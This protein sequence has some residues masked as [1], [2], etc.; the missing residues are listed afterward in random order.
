[1]NCPK[2]NFNINQGENFCRFCGYNLN[3]QKSQINYN[4]ISNSNT[5]SVGMNNQLIQNNIQNGD[6]NS[7]LQQNMEYINQN[8]SFQQLLSSQQT[9]EH[10]NNIY[11]KE[12]FKPQT[13]FNSNY[14]QNILNDE[15]FNDDILIDTY[16]GKRIDGLK[17]GGFSW[18]TFFGGILY[19]F[20]RKMWLLGIIWYVLLVIINNLLR[21]F[22]GIVGFII[23]IVI[24]FIFKERYLEHVNK[25]VEEIKNRNQNKTQDEIME[26]C[27]KKGGTTLIP[28]FVVFGIL[29][30]L[31]GIVFYDVI[32]AYNDTK[33]KQEQIKNEFISSNNEL[34]PNS[35]EK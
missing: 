4:Q 34:L 6:G 21:S 23:N 15:M 8:N 5:T 20:Y 3:S 7:T 27:R 17:K 31:L 33:E 26:I 11:P 18:C 22:A 25:K 13:V 16:I 30:V 28:I 29:I 10:Q 12:P 24:A 1:M 9:N 35:K 14:A 32:D 19:V 2:C